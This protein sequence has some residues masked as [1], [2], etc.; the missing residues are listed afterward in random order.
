MRN[1]FNFILR[2]HAFFLFLLL[3][4]VCLSLVVRN[5]DSQRKIF[6]SSA[7]FFT[8]ALYEEYDGFTQYL[9]MG[10]V[11]DSLAKEN[12]HIY[13]QL[14]NAKFSNLVVSDTAQVDSIYTQRYFYIAAKVVNNSSTLQNNYLTLNRGH[15]HGVRRD[16]GVIDGR[17]LVGIVVDVSEH[18]SLVMS[19]LNRQTKISALIKRNG[20]IG[21]LVWKGNDPRFMQLEAVP[22]HVELMKGDTV[23][24]SGYS[25]IFPE[26]LLIGTI[27]DFKIEGGSNFYDI[28]VLLNNNIRTARYVQVVQNI[29]QEE[30]KSLEESI[31]DE[32]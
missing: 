1:L 28:Q 24:T 21:S 4:A 14:E 8:G 22:K 5:N 6:L 27:E 19:L 2:Y 13:Q 29:L 12:S 11:A 15:K 32:Q 31:S 18:F 7:N 9:N 26:G 3:E 10:A 20:E 30:Q 23:I 16:W 17:G 25:T